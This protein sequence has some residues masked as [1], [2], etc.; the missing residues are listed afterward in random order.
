MKIENAG[1]SLRWFKK[2]EWPPF[3]VKVTDKKSICCNTQ[4]GS[5]ECVCYYSHDVKL[6]SLCKL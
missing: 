6:Y 3:P 2:N 4:G 1:I 5:T